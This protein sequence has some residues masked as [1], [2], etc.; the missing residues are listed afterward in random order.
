MMT[1]PRLVPTILFTPL[2]KQQLAKE[3]E[4]RA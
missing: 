3:M 4:G 1:F 2:H